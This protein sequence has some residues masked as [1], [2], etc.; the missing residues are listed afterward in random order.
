MV[1]RRGRARFALKALQEHRVLRHLGRE[2][3]QRHISSQRRVFGFVDHTHPAAA[4]FR[5]HSVMG[6]GSAD[7]LGGHGLSTRE[8]EQM[9]AE[10]A[11]SS[12]R[13]LSVGPRHR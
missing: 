13:V 12:K 9:V 11:R 5:L 4:E 1:E 6:K 2:K 10:R 3:L 7:D 8:Q